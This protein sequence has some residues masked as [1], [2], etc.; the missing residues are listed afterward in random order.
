MLTPQGPALLELNVLEIPLVS[1]VGGSDKG[2]EK[3]QEHM[4]P[5][6]AGRCAGLRGIQRKVFLDPDPE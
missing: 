5:V 6:F 4:H 1:S 2:K 3:E